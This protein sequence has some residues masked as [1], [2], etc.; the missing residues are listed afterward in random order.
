MA[1]SKKPT[2]LLVDDDSMMRNVLKIILKSEGYREIDEASNGEEA[3]AQCLRLRPDLVLLDINMPKMTG[4]QALEGIRKASPTTLV[5][6]VSAE[7]TLD[8]VDEALKK[9]AAGFVVK[10]ITA[11][12][13]LAKVESCLKR[14]ANP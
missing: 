2:V 14:R 1:T 9:G 6:M 8:K 10:P 4:L 12:N 5:L 11:A 3:I 7:S 13:V